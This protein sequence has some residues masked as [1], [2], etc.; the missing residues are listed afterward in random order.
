MSFLLYS[1][2]DELA[3]LICSLLILN[4]LLEPSRTKFL[5]WY[6]TVQ[7]AAINAVGVQKMPI[8]P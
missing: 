7:R 5:A 4:T 1:E 6:L 2:S 3:L 8:F